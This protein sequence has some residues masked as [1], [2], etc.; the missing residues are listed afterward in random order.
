M[1][2]WMKMMLE[3]LL[4][5]FFVTFATFLLMNLSPSDPAEAY[6]KRKSAIVTEEQVEAVR[7]QLGM[8]RPIPVQY[9]S[10]IGKALRLDFGDSLVSGKP[11]R[12][13]MKSAVGVTLG[14][15]VFSTLFMGGI[16]LLVAVLLNVSRYKIITHFLEFL[17]VISISIPHFYIAIVLIDYLALNKGVMK[18]AG[19]TGVMKFIP[20]AL[21]VG[22][23]G[24]FYFGRILADSLKRVMD[25]DFCTFAESRGLSHLRVLWHHGLANA[26]SALIPVFLQCLALSIASIA[27]LE[28]IFSIKGVGFLI[29]DATLKRDAPTLY[30]CILFLGFVIVTVDIIADKIRRYQTAARGGD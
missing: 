24:G 5:L 7:H 11:V 10:W 28:Q 17:T 26:T 21:C 8:D 29:L 20:C 14:V 6:A 9:I 13:L 12:L 2:P 25:M 18:V 27:I 23:S 22:L 3:L 15:M 16:A 4:S 19:N 1:K 30:A